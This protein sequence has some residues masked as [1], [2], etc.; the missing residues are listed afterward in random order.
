M[1]KEN[2][3]EIV[4]KFVYL[5]ITFTTGGSFNETHK[6]LSFQALKGIFKLNQYLYKFTDLSPK[7]I[8]DLFDKLIRPI[9][10][11]GAQVWG[12]S[13]LVQQERIH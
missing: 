1:F 8:L 9:L 6:T 5:G 10:C 11:Y 3:I 13:N 2:K 4:R 12:F 7:H